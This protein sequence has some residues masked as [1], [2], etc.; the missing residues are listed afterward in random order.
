MDKFSLI[1][2]YLA[3]GVVIAFLGVCALLAI[4]HRRMIYDSLQT[5]A[6]TPPPV[7]TPL[8]KS[9][10]VPADYFTQASPSGKIETF[11]YS[12]YDYTQATSEPI[13]KEALVYLPPEYDDSGTTR[14]DIIYWLHGWQMS[15]QEFLTLGEGGTARILDHLINDGKMKPV[16]VVS[17]TFDRDNQEA[18]WERSVAEMTAFRQE[19]RHD[20]L[21]AIEGHYPTYAQS[22]SEKYLQKSRM[23]RA[24]SG[25]SLGAVATWYE[26]EEA[27]DLFAYFIPMSGDS[28]TISENGGFEAT[29]QTVDALEQVAQA[30]PGEFLIIQTNGTKD[31]FHQQIDCMLVEMRR[32]K[33]T[34]NSNNLVY[35]VKQNGEHD[36]FAI[37][38]M[39]YNAF[40]MI[41]QDQS[42]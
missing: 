7:P 41:F 10:I 13:I 26:F 35:L 37:W 21:P 30:A 34:F 39:V 17:T 20:L 27:L 3:V 5:P 6:V 16:I 9:K 2:Q 23:H 40:P 18:D 36:M 31:F 24:F 8:T 28:W 29:W 15:N 42:A 33:N 22:A 12:T 19:V 11:A 1:K 14:Y 38:E 32:R 25:F 4:N